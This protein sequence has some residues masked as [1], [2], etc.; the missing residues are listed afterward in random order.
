MEQRWKICDGVV[1]TCEGVTAVVMNFRRDS[2][3]HLNE[4]GCAVWQAIAGGDA[5]AA[6]IKRLTEAAQATSEDRITEE[7]GT[8]LEQLADAGLIAPESRS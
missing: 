4:T 7:V 3:F 2:C 1:A 5:A 6:T 8:F